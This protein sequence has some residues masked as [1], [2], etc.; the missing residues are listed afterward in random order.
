[1]TQTLKQQYR[2]K[3]G[4]LEDILDV[5]IQGGR[6]GVIISAISRKANLAHNTVLDKCEGLISAGLVDSSTIKHNRIFLISEKGI[7]FFQ[8]L[9]RFQSLAESVNLRY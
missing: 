5:I 3:M 9:R 2:T 7:H 1:M 8:E 6:E 4:I